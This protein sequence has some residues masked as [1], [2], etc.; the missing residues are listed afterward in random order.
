MPPTNAWKRSGRISTS[1]ASSGSAS[2]RLGAAAAAA[3]DALHA[4]DHLL[5]VAGLGDPVV[6]AEAQPAHALGDGRGA[7]AD[8]DAE[9][10]QR[11]AEALE[12][13]PGLRAEHG[14]VDDERAEPHRDD[15]L[16]GHRAGEHAVLPAEAVQALAEHL[17][18][19]AVAVEHGDPQ[20][21]RCAPRGSTSA[22]SDRRR[23]RLPSSRRSVS[24]R[25]DRGA[26]SRKASQDVHRDVRYLRTYAAP[27]RCFAEAARQGADSPHQALGRP[28]GAASGRTPAGCE[29]SENSRNRPVTTNATCSPM[30]TA[31]S[32]IR[33]SARATS[34]HVHRP[35]A[36]VGVVAD[37]DRQAEDLAVQAV[38]LAVLAD[39]VLGQADV[40]P[41]ERGLRLDDLRAGV[42]AHLRRAL[43][44]SPGAPAARGRRAGSAWRCSRTG[45]PSARCA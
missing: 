14:E 21:L 24:D 41:G 19:A 3:H 15:R 44:A 26:C 38:D 20:R 27:A 12:P 28:S 42:G 18:E 11:L 39:E 13:L 29:E 34:D 6:G 40:A 7:G 4:R 30:S 43:R 35:L 8:D 23:E 32:P 16:G 36:R 2:V 1:P 9:L 45:R 33:S 31:L 5:G 17:D 22:A 37:L 25:A 10:R